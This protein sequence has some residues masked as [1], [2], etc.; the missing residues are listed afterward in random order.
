MHSMTASMD[1]AD[2]PSAQN[3]APCDHAESLKTATVSP[4]SVKIDVPV[5]ALE[6]V[7]YA[8]VQASWVQ[9]QEPPLH[10]SSDPPP[11]DI[12]LKRKTVFLI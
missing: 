2:M 9:R 1:M 12:P 8:L 4:A 6:P 3:W 5:P 11:P 7:N 10:W